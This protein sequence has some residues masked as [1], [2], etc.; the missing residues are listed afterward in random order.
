MDQFDVEL[1]TRDRFA[2]AYE[3][4]PYGVHVNQSLR[5]PSSGLCLTEVAQPRGTYRTPGTED[6]VLGFVRNGNASARMDFGHGA[7]HFEATATPLFLS[8]ARTPSVVDARHAHEA[9]LLSWPSERLHKAFDTLEHADP[10]VLSSLFKTGFQS[11]LIQ[12]VINMLLGL[13]RANAAIPS[14]LEQS[15]EFVLAV[16]LTRVARRLQEQEGSY[17]VGGLSPAKLRKAQAYLLEHLSDQITLQDVANH[18]E[19]SP[20]HF[21]RCFLSSV[22]CSPHRWRLQARLA[23]ACMLLRTTRMTITE[24]AHDVG[25]LSSQAFTRGFRQ[26]L[27]CTPAHYRRYPDEAFDMPAAQVRSR[28]A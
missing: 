9:V 22:G 15:I 4:G 1:S 7:F 16:E 6:Y 12:G 24:I 11:T 18:V 23:R 13:S 27:G 2:D 8:P 5:L 25:Y 21:W 10:K 3:A 17:Q 14:L 26:E 19:M 28:S 20:F